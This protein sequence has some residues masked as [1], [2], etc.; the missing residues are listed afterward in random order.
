MDGK[1]YSFRIRLKLPDNL[2]IGINSDR[3]FLTPENSKPEI[4]LRSKKD[5]LPISESEKL[6][7]I[8]NGYNSENEAYT[9][10]EEVRDAITLA[11]ARLRIGADFGDRAPRGVVTDAGLRMFE[12][13]T[14]RR[15]L[16]DVHGLMIFE[17]DP[18]PKFAEIDVS[19][20]V[21]KGQNK[22][23]EALNI[24][25]SLRLKL[26]MEHRLAFDLFSASFFEPNVDARLL[27][28]MMAIETLLTLRPRSVEVKAHVD[29]LIHFTK[30]SPKI[31]N[32]EKE[33]LIGSLQW[34]YK[35]SIR[36][37]GRRLADQLA[38]QKYMDLEPKKFF[39]HCYDLRSKLIHGYVPRPTRDEVNRVVG[40]LEKFVGD[41]LSGTLLQ[42]VTI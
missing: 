2:R 4:A 9:A 41:L 21:I 42:Q 29:E 18:P 27:M 24:A 28:L 3:W 31:G 8:G 16:N 15:V 22:F 30:E 25:L 5:G 32:E 6:I 34:L 35:E 38:S 19:A 7:I 11:F 17:A 1:S 39:D 23:L 20:V 12:E 26:R 14:G 40:E 13:Q 37:A 10:G 36:K 33:S